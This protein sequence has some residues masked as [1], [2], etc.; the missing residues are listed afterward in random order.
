MERFFELNF[1]LCSKMYIFL[2][3][4]ERKDFSESFKDDVCSWLS[5]LLLHSKSAKIKAIRE[6]LVQKLSEKAN[7]LC[8]A[9]RL[10]M[11]QD[12]S[13]KT[14]E[15][16]SRYFEREWVR[17]LKIL[18][19]TFYNAG[20]SLDTEINDHNNKSTEFSYNSNEC[21]KTLSKLIEI[22]ENCS[23]ESE[24]SIFLEIWEVL[25]TLSYQSFEIK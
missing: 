9:Y 18:K 24:T 23:K 25:C 20:Q 2:N 11:I 15:K 19:N 14:G 4:N 7:E 1:V 6:N 16:D 8:T 5:I 12:N 13:N 17:I 21:P 22:L 3:K 10:S